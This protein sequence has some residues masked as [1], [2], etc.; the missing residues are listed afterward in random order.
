MSVSPAA[1]RDRIAGA[2]ATVDASAPHYDAAEDLAKVHAARTGATFV[3]PCTGVELMAG[4][5]TVALEILEELPT[6]R[7]MIT[8]VGGGGLCGGM[9]GFL[10]DAAPHVT[11]IGAQSDR[12]D[13]MARAMRAGAP[14]GAA[15]QRQ[16][17][18]V[19]DKVGRN[20]MC[21]CGSGLKFK[22][23]HGK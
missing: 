13:A 18:H 3:S 2:G 15:P 5:G 11:L 9:G 17:I 7:T 6:V 8:N 16:P 21:P 23:C 10:N 22:K 12:T 20:Q 19:A 14:N 1:K 4:Q